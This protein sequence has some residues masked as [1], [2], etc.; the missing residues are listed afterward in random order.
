[1]VWQLKNPKEAQQL[2]AVNRLSRAFIPPCDCTALLLDSLLLSDQ[3]FT[4]HDA[5]R[6][7]RNPRSDRFLV[8]NHDFN[9]SF[10]LLVYESNANTCIMQMQKR[11]I[12]NHAFA[13]LLSVHLNQGGNVPST[14]IH[15]PATLENNGHRMGAVTSVG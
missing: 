14:G 8:Q 6:L 1:M 9:L 4:L 5:I 12:Q 10:L 13:R 2:N 7:N 3:S 11:S 15:P